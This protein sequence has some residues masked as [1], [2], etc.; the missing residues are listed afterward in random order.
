MPEGRGSISTNLCGG[1]TLVTGAPGD[2][3]KTSKM[4]SRGVRIY[5][6]KNTSF[7]DAAFSTATRGPEVVAYT[8]FYQGEVSLA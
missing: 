3:R 7:R 2:L 6:R 1:V 5:F 8:D 4:R